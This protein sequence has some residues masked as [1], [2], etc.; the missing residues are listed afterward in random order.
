MRGDRAECATGSCASGTDGTAEGVYIPAVR[1]FE[2]SDI[3]AFVSSV[4][5]SEEKA[6]LGQSFLGQRL[7]RRHSWIGRG[8]DTQVCP[9]PGEEGSPT[10]TAA[11]DRLRLVLTAQLIGPPPLGAGPCPPYGGNF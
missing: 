11:I 8:H 7:L 1:A 3:D 2:G 10:G 5:V 4:P 6:L 9:L